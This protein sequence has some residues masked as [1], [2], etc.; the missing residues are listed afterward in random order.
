MPLLSIEV[1]APL[2]ST[3][4][5]EMINSGVSSWLLLYIDCIKFFLISWFCSKGSI[6]PLN[7]NDMSFIVI[8]LFP[9][10]ANMLPEKSNALVRCVGSR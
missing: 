1:L 6:T 7:V 4:K 5:E 9:S 10:L 2:G 3:L 8:I